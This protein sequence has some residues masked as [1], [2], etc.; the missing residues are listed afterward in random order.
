MAPKA[1][2]PA[3]WWQVLLIVTLVSACAV[4]VPPTGGPPD[5][6]PPAL[7]F[8]EPAAGSVD[9]ETD[10]L[11]F[12]FSEPVDEASLLNAFSITPELL[13]PIE[14]KSSGRTVTVRLP[15]TLREETTYRVTLDTSLRDRRSVSLDAPIT[16]AFATGL[17]IDTAKLAGHMVR[18]TDGS[19]ASGI[20][21]LAYASPD[22]A[23]LADGPL[24]RTQTGSDGRFVLDYVRPASYFIVGLQDLNRNRVIDSGEWLAIPP[25]EALVADIMDAVPTEPWILSQTDEEAP[26]LDRVRAISDGEL[27][28]RMSEAL[29]LPLDRP[30]P[31]GNSL[32]LSDS[33]G[34]RQ[35][36]V[37]SLWF[38]QQHARTLFAQVNDLTPGTWTLSGSLALADSAGNTTDSILAVFTVPSGLPAPDEASFLSWT[39]DTLV[40]TIGTSSAEQPRTVW[41]Q[42]RVGFRL[43]RPAEEV[44]VAFIDSSSQ[45]V[46]LPLIRED[47]T[48]Y[49]WD[50]SSAP[51]PYQVQIRIPGADSTYSIWLEGAASSQLGALGIAINP[52]PFSS[53]D[54]VGRIMPDDGGDALVSAKMDAGMMLFDHLPRGF[55]GRMLVFVDQ[56]GDGT[57]NP[58]S[59]SPY[60]PAEPV[61]WHTF[62]ER[63]RPRWE[64]IAADTLRFTLPAADAVSTEN[65]E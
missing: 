2:S 38:R 21:V 7:E 23:S 57:W 34:T 24:Y 43:T 64:T 65:D 63:V 46:P 15:E 22:S 59:L 1:H 26:V 51:R 10:R 48:L 49:S 31:S 6:T 33:A 12:T 47:A 28:L 14:V 20:D 60:V 19:P 58:G 16:L 50:D 4:P 32:I 9:V 41:L 3:K 52:A 54:L 25:M 40:S 45:R 11:T 56:D 8:S 53:D 17:E 37:T 18:A 44:S 30:F 27:E 29:R 39:P 42:E 5:A 62:R 61:R 55:R 13:G 36:P 35:V